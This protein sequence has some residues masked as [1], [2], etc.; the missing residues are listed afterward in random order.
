MANAIAICKGR[1]KEIA[2]SGWIRKRSKINVKAI[3]GKSKI[4]GLDTFRRPDLLNST[5]ASNLDEEETIVCVTI[6]PPLSLFLLLNKPG[7]LHDLCIK[8]FLPAPEVL[9]CKLPCVSAQVL[10][11]SFVL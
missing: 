6:F 2:M 1:Y 5:G 10:S 9:F 8:P 7:Y 3:I 11:E 4:S